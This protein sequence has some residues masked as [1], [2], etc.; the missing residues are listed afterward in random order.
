MLN[1][2]SGPKCDYVYVRLRR[3]GKEQWHVASGEA[4]R[5]LSQPCGQVLSSLERTEALLAG[6]GS[7][8]AILVGLSCFD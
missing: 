7:L 8:K 2:L 3:M 6:S 1:P 4:L 5:R